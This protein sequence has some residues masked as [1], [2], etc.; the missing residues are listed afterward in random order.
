ML[1]PTPELRARRVLRRRTCATSVHMGQCCS[2]PDHIT[3]ADSASNDVSIAGDDQFR[4]TLYAVRHGEAVHNVKEKE[5]KITAE[6]SLR[7]SQDNRSLR[8]GPY[9]GQMGDS[10]S[11]FT[12]YDIIAN[13]DSSFNTPY[14]ALVPFDV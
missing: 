6:A 14:I 10:A 11:S 1:T 5:A 7:A 2:Q 9:I 4:I 13:T 8:E 12:K 3:A